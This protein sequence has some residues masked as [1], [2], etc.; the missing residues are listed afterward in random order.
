MAGSIREQEGFSLTPISRAVLAACG[1][2]VAVTAAPLAVAQEVQALEEIIVTARADGK[3]A[4]R[5]Y[6]RSGDHCGGNCET[7]H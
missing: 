1:T 5:S 2:T 3:S 4:R 7:R 6:K